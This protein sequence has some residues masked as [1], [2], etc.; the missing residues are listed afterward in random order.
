MNFDKYPIKIQ[1]I[2]EYVFDETLRE[3]ADYKII[4]YCNLLTD[5]G[6][7]KNDYALLG[8]SGY[9]RGEIYYLQ[10][11]V[12][13]FYKEMFLCMPL[14][15]KAKEHLYFALGNN[16][17]GIMSINSGNAPFAMDHYINAL[18]TCKKYNLIDI[19]WIIHINIGTLY[20]RV[21]DE[22][23]AIIHL[24][25]AY[26][27][28][29]KHKD[30]DDYK[31]N[32]SVAYTNLG[33]AYIEKGNIDEAKVYWYKLKKECLE[34]LG[35][36]EKIATY[37]FAARLYNA[38][39]DKKNRDNSIAIVKDIVK[40]NFAVMDVFDDLYEFMQLLIEIDDFKSFS[41]I[42]DK[43]YN[44]TEKTTVKDM[45]IRL[46]KLKLVYFEKKDDEE[47]F[48]KVAIQYAKISMSENR[49]N[50]R[51]QK[52]MIALRANLKHLT[53]INHRVERE[54]EILQKKSETDAL[55]GMFNRF[56][57]NNF[58]EEAF[59]DAYKNEKMIAIE[60]V[61]ID[62]FKEYNDNYG[63]QAGDYC[64][65]TISDC[66]KR[67]VEENN[68]FCARYGGDEFVILYQNITYDDV[69]KI[70]KTLAKY[71]YDSNIMHNYSKISDRV[72]VSQGVCC[73]IPKG[74]ERSFDFMFSADKMLY[75]VKDKGKNGIEIGKCNESEK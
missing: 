7:K 38:L 73:D 62:Y 5:Y 59:E 6:N 3:E 46:L 18:E 55:T 8:F 63:H 2:I 24:L 68:L 19:E 44:L 39:L 20:L 10:N 45:I 54:N 33:K 14:L 41:F 23:N 74:R 47:N 17:L 69:F 26:D 56:K 64:I 42:W 57:L 60:I 48:S 31:L 12:T 29:K 36:K 40:T 50:K 61:D 1:N 21:D 35:K 52:N 75:L 15:E 34:F 22:E 49:A 37:S 67:V 30:Y 25:K 58:W 72:T 32:L 71:I 70:T 51:M 16:V 66:I 27:Y 28:I 11:N 65:K 9:I 4:E 43:V 53:D 13:L